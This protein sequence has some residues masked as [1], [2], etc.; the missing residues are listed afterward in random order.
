MSTITCHLMG[1]LGNQLFQIFAVMDYAFRHGAEFIFT[2]EKV[3]KTGIS[4]RTYWND[5]LYC[6]KAH[7]SDRR[8]NLFYR[9][10]EFS[11]KDIPWTEGQE[12]LKIVGYFQ[13]PKYFSRHFEDICDYLEIAEMR[14]RVAEAVGDDQFDIAMHFRIGDFVKHKEHPIMP[15]HYYVNALKYVVQQDPSARNVIIFC[16]DCDKELVN[17]KITEISKKVGLSFNFKFASE[18]PLEKDWEKMLFIGLCKHKIIANSTFS[19][20]GAYLSKEKEGN[21]IVCYPEVW[22]NNDHDTKDLFPEQW[23]KI[24]MNSINK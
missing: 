7:T 3:L 10:P 16:Q 1:G 13:S 5:F 14:N 12:E 4:R 9:E 21:G 18:Y 8:M 22:F 6:L 19:W 2:S 24:K 11:H 15:I 17:T 23:I 20:W